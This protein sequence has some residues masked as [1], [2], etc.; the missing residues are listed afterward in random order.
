MTTH[1]PAIALLD[2]IQRSDV[3]A[4]LSALALG[5]SVTARHVFKTTPLHIAVLCYDRARSAHCRARETA[6]EKIVE[7]LLDAGADPQARDANGDMPSV[8]A[9]NSGAP[10]CLALRMRQLAE[11]GAFPDPRVPRLRDAPD[12]IEAPTGCIPAS[13]YSCGPAARSLGY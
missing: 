8:W 7:A 9:C 10:R 11:A 12:P 2:A 6:A 13:T 5:A 1:T 4:A 3:D